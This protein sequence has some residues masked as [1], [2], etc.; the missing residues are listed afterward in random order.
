MIKEPLSIS[1][2]EEE[3]N[4]KGGGKKEGATKKK[5]KKKKLKQAHARTQKIQ[6]NKLF[7]VH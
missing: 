2:R 6:P 5:K 3:K 7:W 4:R 1:W